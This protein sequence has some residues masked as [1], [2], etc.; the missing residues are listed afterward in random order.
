[1]KATS[2]VPSK[3]TYNLTVT[4]PDGGSVTSANSIVNQ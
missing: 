1:V 4:N 3:G 2:G